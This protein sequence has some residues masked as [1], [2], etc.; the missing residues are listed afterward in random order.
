MGTTLLLMSVAQADPT[1][2]TQNSSAV[3]QT[4]QQIQPIL[5][6]IIVTDSGRK[7]VID[8]KVFF[9]AQQKEGLTVTHIGQQKVRVEYM[10]NGKLIQD[11][12]TLTD[13]SFIT[14]SET[15][16]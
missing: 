5:S 4:A 13:T 10:H 16:K 15:D 12:L 8:G 9:E 11:E 7:A 3:Q 6:A 14:K 1:K 2:P